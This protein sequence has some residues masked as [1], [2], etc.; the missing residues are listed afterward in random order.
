MFE[1]NLEKKSKTRFWQ[2]KKIIFYIDIC[3]QKKFKLKIQNF[4]KLTPN[5]VRS[6][7]DIKFEFFSV[8]F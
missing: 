2:L 3:S 4:E 8:K 1:S 5:L 7:L 6:K